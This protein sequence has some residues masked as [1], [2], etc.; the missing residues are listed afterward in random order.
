MHTL[1]N[2]PSL[3]TIYCCDKGG[4]HLVVHNANIGMTAPEF[5]KLNDEV[6]AARERLDEGNWPS[7][8]V[9]VT[10]KSTMIC[11]L[12]DTLSKLADA[13]VTAMA[14]I[15]YLY[16]LG[17]INLSE[18]GLCEANRP[19][20]AGFAGPNKSVDKIDTNQLLNN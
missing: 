18:H 14:G 8:F 4:I 5:A 12:P 20:V 10:Y 2:E 9:G 11:L 13:M 7:P 19:H 17:A 1:A 16:E 3:T 15:D 6:Q